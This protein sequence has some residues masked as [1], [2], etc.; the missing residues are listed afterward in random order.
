MAREIYG[1]NVKTNQL[2][3][4]R[5]ISY[6]SICNSLMIFEYDLLFNKICKKLKVIQSSKSS[7]SQPYLNDRNV[8][9]A[10]DSWRDTLLEK[11]KNKK[12]NI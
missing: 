6:V 9:A 7:W 1:D 11:T 3:K 12:N 8:C 2:N 5:P 10:D 4:T